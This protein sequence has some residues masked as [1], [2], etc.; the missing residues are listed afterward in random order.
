MFRLIYHLHIRATSLERLVLKFVVLEFVGLVTADRIWVKPPTRPSS[1]YA[2]DM[3]YHH[4]P[5][6]LFISRI[7]FISLLPE[8]LIFISINGCGA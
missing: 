4:L 3:D 5:T 7:I 8:T 2:R 6:S 1:L